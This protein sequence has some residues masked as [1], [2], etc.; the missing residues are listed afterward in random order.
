M[1]RKWGR[2]RY[3]GSAL[4]L[5]P[6]LIGVHL[7]HRFRGRLRVGR[8]IET[9]AYMGPEDKA[10]HARHGLTRRNQ[11]MFGGPGIAYVY[12]VYG[13][14]NCLNIVTGRKGDAQAV[15]LRGVQDL[16]SGQD[17]HGPGRLCR[18]LGVGL[19]LDGEDLCGGRLWLEDAPRP[20]QKPLVLAS[21]RVGV[22]YAGA[23]AAKPWRFREA[24]KK[25]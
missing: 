18:H 5:A 23:W 1:P 4:A 20:R 17:I 2:R 22:D 24:R 15:L 7:V 12:F 16:D 3:E 11:T 6:A 14:W 9:E 8:I 25:S 19:N 10:S 13:M 21:P